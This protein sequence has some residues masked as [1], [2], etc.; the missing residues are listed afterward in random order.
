MRI[1]TD[2]EEDLV[3]SQKDVL[4]FALQQNEGAAS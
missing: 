4:S 1:H 2:T 3:Q